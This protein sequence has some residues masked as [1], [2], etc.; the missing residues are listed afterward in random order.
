MADVEGLDPPGGFDL[1]VA[2]YLL[3]Y[4]DSPAVSSEMC[5]RSAGA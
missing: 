4:A 2:A 5:R 3:N 1:V